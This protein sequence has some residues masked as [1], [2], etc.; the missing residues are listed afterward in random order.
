MA[1]LGEA[2]MSGLREQIK[3]NAVMLFPDITKLQRKNH[4]NAAA[5]NV[6]DVIVTYQSVDQA[7]QAWLTA[8]ASD[9]SRLAHKGEF[10]QTV[11]GAIRNLLDSTGM[12]LLTQYSELQGIPPKE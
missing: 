8:W 5:T 12:T 3:A 9:A 6:F 7:Y 11:E 4:P 2:S 1:H 10:A